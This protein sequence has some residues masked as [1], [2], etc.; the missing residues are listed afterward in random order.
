MTLW[1]RPLERVLQAHAQAAQNARWGI[2]AQI[3]IQV[4][5][6]HSFCCTDLKATFGTKRHELNVSTYQMV[7]L[8]LFNEAEVVSYEDIAAQTSI[9]P[10]DLK[11]SLQSLALVRV[12]SSS[13]SILHTGSDS[14]HCYGDGWAD[15]CCLD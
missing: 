15:E 1:S 7:I 10:S 8:L 3:S 5:F 4:Q 12:L 6:S 2:G 13:S 11:R 9:P 14:H